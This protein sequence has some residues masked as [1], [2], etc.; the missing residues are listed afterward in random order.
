MGILEYLI[1]VAFRGAVL[2][3]DIAAVFILI[4]LACSHAAVPLLVTYNTAGRPLVDGLLRLT[5]DAWWRFGGCR[6]LT[7]W[8]K[9]LLALS[10]LSVVRVIVLIVMQLVL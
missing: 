5:Q 9:L 2:M 8:Q 7:D 4:R 10:G 1:F 3:I 6:V